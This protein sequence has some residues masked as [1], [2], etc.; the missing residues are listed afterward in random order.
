MWEL[1]YKESWVPKNWCF[2][3]VVL[4]ETIESPLDCEKIQQVHSKGNQAWIF[5]GR[6]DAEAETAILWPP[7]AKIWL[8]GKDPFGG[9]D[10]RWEEKETTE[11]G[12]DGWMASPTQW[13]W[14]WVNSGSWGWTGRPGMLQST[15]SQRVGH[16]WET[17][18]NWLSNF[19][20]GNM[21]NC[22]RISQLSLPRFIHLVMGSKA[23][24]AAVHGVSKSRTW[25]SDWTE[26]NWAL[27]FK[28]FGIQL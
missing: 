5:I 26:L 12:W 18:L 16:N 28:L 22:K 25:L 21:A 9:K 13:T 1:D 17:E 14:V 20:N 4:E 2:C 15:G 27:K 7:D 24:H 19:V 3:T 8:I 23:W 11:D 6:T 10:W